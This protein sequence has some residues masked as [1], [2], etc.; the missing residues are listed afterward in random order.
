MTDQSDQAAK[1]CVVVSGNTQ[2]ASLICLREIGFE[3]GFEDGDRPMWTAENK[4]V[5]LAAWSPEELL[6]VA[7]V[8]KRFG[9]SFAGCDPDL[10]SSLLEGVRSEGAD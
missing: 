7:T 5:R 1:A 10:I 4:E 2:N 9:E 3:L 6:G 8:W